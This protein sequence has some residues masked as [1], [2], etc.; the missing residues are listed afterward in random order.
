MSPS[1]E[2]TVNNLLSLSQGQ[3]VPI[4]KARSAVEEF[5]LSLENILL[6][7]G[8]SQSQ[9]TSLVQA[10][11]DQYST[12]V[13]HLKVKRSSELIDADFDSLL[14]QLP[15]IKKS[16]HEDIKAAY[17][18]DPAAISR[19]EIIISYP[20]IRT[21][22]SHRIA[23]LLFQRKVPLL[24]R[25]ISEIS[26]SKTGIDIHPGASIG[27][28]CFLDHGTGIVIGETA[29]IGDYCRIYQ[30]VT[31]GSKSFPQNEDGTLVKAIPRHPIVE[32]HVVIYAGA[33]ILGRITI[34]HHSI[35]GGNVWITETVPANSRIL[36]TRY[37][38]AFFRDGEGI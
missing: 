26:H 35:I 18:G 30:G 15:T 1:L 25:L 8:H 28:G 5:I 24:P 3:T 21:M 10:L 31:L 11:L 27:A 2:Y 6:K 14:T 33:T 17:E 20:S 23:H 36:Q 16:L 34:G 13:E 4:H 19:E 12:I 37:Q 22:L 7:D 32:S 29:I 9:L 38:Q